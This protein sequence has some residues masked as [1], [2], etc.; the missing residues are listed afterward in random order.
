MS[1]PELLGKTDNE[2]LENL[3]IRSY[4]NY[5]IMTALGRGAGDRAR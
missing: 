4:F 2:M 1:M 3:N 5:I